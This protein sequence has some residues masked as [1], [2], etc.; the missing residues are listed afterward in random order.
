MFGHTRSIL[1][2]VFLR[3]NQGFFMDLLRVPRSA[4]GFDCHTDPIA[5]VT[6][7][8]IDLFLGV[9]RQLAHCTLRIG[10]R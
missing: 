5:R 8:E 2:N 6:S 1:H 3:A 4:S 9:K 10:L 7:D